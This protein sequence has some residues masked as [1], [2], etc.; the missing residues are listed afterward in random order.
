MYRPERVV[1]RH[2]HP[3]DGLDEPRENING[4]IAVDNLNLPGRRRTAGLNPVRQICGPSQQPIAQI[5]P[6][7]SSDHVV[8]LAKDAVA[9]ARQE[10]QHSVDH[11][12]N[13]KD[14]LRPGLTIDLGHQDIQRIPEE[15]VN[16][17]KDEIER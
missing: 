5:S 15:V 2:P 9:A 3:N 7:N 13:V 16:I 11:A 6:S 8:K 10:T 1:K 17:I 4:L 14:S 12:G